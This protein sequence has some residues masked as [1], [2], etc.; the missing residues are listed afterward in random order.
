LPYEVWRKKTFAEY[1]FYRKHYSLRTVARIRRADMFK[2]RYRLF[3]LGLLNLFTENSSA[4]EGK[5]VKYRA[6]CDTLE[7]IKQ[8]EVIDGK[9]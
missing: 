5:M 4:N 1:H 3:T 2:A 8:A 9:S 7:E 6:I